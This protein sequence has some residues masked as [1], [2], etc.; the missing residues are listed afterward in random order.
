MPDKPK[1]LGRKEW[2]ALPDLGLPAIKAKVD[3]GARTSALHADDIQPVGSPEQPSVRFTVHPLPL[4]PDIAVVCTARVLAE[5]EVTSSNGERERRYIIETRLRV[6]DRE[7][8]I[9]V[10][11]TNRGSMSHR[12]LL[13]RQGIPPDFMVDPSGTYHQ[14]K[15]GARSY[16]AS[17][18]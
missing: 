3:T 12:M 2:V 18:R 5:R 1:T 10:G 15:L 16:K 11:L 7:W 14:P 8:P 13:G 4:R 17:T 9:E 6:G